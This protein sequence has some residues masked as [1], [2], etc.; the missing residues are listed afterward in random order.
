VDP[1]NRIWLLDLWRKQAVSDEW[2][3]AWCDLV[4]QWNPLDWA[5]ETGQITAG[6]G[7]FRDARAAQRQAYTNV[8]LFPTRGDKA[9][10]AQSIRGRMAMGG[11]YV[12]TAAP[13]FAD[14]RAELLS[15][16]AGRTDDQVDAL[17][18]VGQLLDRMIP[19][20]V[21]KPEKPE[22]VKSGYKPIEDFENTADWRTV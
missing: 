2:I 10:R 9:V 13:W 3:D 11:L 14:F 8:E 19:G 1:E 22:E 20:C 5:E 4:R 16:D 7:P 17:G 15:F 21:P 18:L 12:P 6:I